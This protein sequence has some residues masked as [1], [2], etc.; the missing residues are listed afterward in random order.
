MDVLLRIGGDMNLHAVPWL[1]LGLISPVLGAALAARCRDARAGWRIAFSSSGA[2][3]ACSLL[4][5]AGHIALAARGE[6]S[7]PGVIDRLSGVRIF[8]LDEMTGPLLPFVALLHLLIVAGTTGGKAARLSFG[9]LLALESV[10]LAA[11][12][13]IHPQV[14][15]G[16]LALGTVVPVFELSSR[17]RSIRL[18]SAHMGIF[19][20][21]LGLGLGVGHREGYATTLAWVPLTVAVLI[22]CGIAPFHLW[23]GDLFSRGAFGTA[24]LVVTPM[25]GVLA[26]VRL[27]VPVCPDAA[28]EPLGALSLV[29][30]VYA[31]GLA[32]VQV[33]VRRFMACLCIGNTAL[34]LTGISLGSEIGVTAALGLW[35]S[36]GIAL[37]G[38]AFALRAAESR[39]GVITL[40]EFR[41]L[42]SRAP[43][44]AV[45]F[46][47]AG[48]ATVG[49]PG[50][51]GLLPLEVLIERAVA[52]NIL[53][54][55]AIAIAIALNGF[56]I[57]RAYAIVFTGRPHAS[58]IPLSVTQRERFTVL[59]LALLVFVG[60]VLPQPLLDSRQEA[61]RALIEQRARHSPATPIPVPRDPDR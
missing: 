8:G 18:Y 49:F 22:R 15:A 35:I 60:G 25:T 47:S 3:F 51:L 58:V 6:P 26:A 13:A 17:G 54:G 4:A 31:A 12:A 39:I 29:T 2:A 19:L 9:S 56:A 42:Y 41:G 46:L 53:I 36:A 24:I 33:E 27:L 14:L 52:A 43:A 5:W 28:L 57:L 7:P 16:L 38:A 61:A 23:I 45:C 20:L 44:L 37:T 30:A 55:P 34:V 40:V 10:N 59:A 50:T 1:E 11:F 32:V 48:L 21:L